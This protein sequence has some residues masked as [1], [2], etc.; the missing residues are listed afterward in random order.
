[1]S[2]EFT[3]ILAEGG[4]SRDRER[5]KGREDELRG[6]REGSSEPEA[7]KRGKRNKRGEKERSSTEEEEVKIGVYI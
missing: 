4:S 5:K 1:M 2:H 3:Y 7:A 6:M